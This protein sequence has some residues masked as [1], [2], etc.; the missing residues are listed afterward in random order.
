MWKTRRKE[1]KKNDIQ[2][3]YDGLVGKEAII[4]HNQFRND[5]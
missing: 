3:V 2:K 5:I 4:K 1:Q